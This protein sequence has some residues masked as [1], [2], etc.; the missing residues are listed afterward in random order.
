MI[1]IEMPDGTVL[2]FPEGTG[3]DVMAAQAKQYMQSLQQPEP[4]ATP[5][6]EP[7]DAPQ[8]QQGLLNAIGERGLVRGIYENVISPEEP[9]IDQRGV[10]ETLYQNYFGRGA[11]DT[12]GE[13][14]VEAARGIAPAIVRGMVDVPALPANLLQLGTAGVEKL[15]GMEQ[16]S[17]VSRGLN[18]LP[19]TRDMLGALP[20][21]GEESRYKAPGTL[22]EF[23]STVGEFVGGAGVAAGPKA[24]MRYGAVPGLA[25]EAAGQATEGTAIEPYARAA[26][27]LGTSIAAT[28]RPSTFTRQIGSA[29]DE[30][31][32]M[33]NRLSASGVKPTAGQVS[34]SATLMKL[35]GTLA[36]RG[37]QLDDFTRAVIKT[38]GGD[39]ARATP[40]VLRTT[41]NKITKG[42]NDILSNTDVPITPSIGQKSFEVS[43]DYFTGT[44]GAQLP[45]SLRRVAD[46]LMDVATTP[47][48][49]GKAATIPASLMRKWRTTLGTYTT[50]SNELTRDAAH[51]LREVIDDATETTLR[52]LGRTEDISKLSNLRNEYRNFLAITD[53]STRGGREA[54]R[55]ILTP[56]R[57]DTAVKRIQG[58]TNYAT[59]RGNELAD[60]S[61]AALSVIGSKPTVAAGG[62]RD[63]LSS[64]L[65]F[66]AAG[67]GGVAGFGAAGP[68]GAAAGAGLGLV[69]P[70]AGQALM[71][72]GPVQTM[73]LNP[74]GFA[75]PIGATL[76][77]LLSQ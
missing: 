67:A 51:A 48:A 4:Q 44:P 63:T 70:G 12:P 19:D 58:R 32:H 34:D 75:A 7:Q 37:G 45:V 36:P 15:L 35:E 3:Q 2:E 64:A 49:A 61:R 68:L 50:S 53:A 30:V 66:G 46:E 23:I 20:V 13:K 14:V 59:G 26:A 5:Q 74:Q 40:K 18:A 71:R 6:P 17:M 65:P 10:V 73:L 62:V 25:S 29:D 54:A 33:A 38:A 69:A 77:G 22:G 60:L 28:P 24:M 39:A 76:P 16:P 8:E 11:V 56:E 41:Q 43:K 55:G 31:L 47:T 1:E 52:Q 21:I 57:V 72:S 27:A 42:M 9:P